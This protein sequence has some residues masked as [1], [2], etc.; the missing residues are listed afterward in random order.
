[1]YLGNFPKKESLRKVWKMEGK[2][3]DLLKKT[4]E[5]RRMSQTEL[6]EEI[7]KQG[8]E[9]YSAADVSK[10]E[11][12]WYKPPEAVVEL[13]EEDIFHLPKGLLL[14]AAGYLPAAESRR[15][16]SRS[17]GHEN[18]KD[19]FLK[20]IQRF[21]EE[22]QGVSLVRSIDA[23]EI[24][25]IVEA[26]E[27]DL[28]LKTKAGDIVHYRWQ[29]DPDGRLVLRCP[30]ECEPEFAY[31]RE[32]LDDDGLWHDYEEWQEIGKQLIL[33]LGDRTAR[34]GLR[35]DYGVVTGKNSAVRP[36]D[37]RIGLNKLAQNISRRIKTM[38]FES[39]GLPG[40]CRYCLQDKGSADV[41]D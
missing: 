37:L 3:G 27:Y 41:S 25:R 33:R 10:W 34:G 24:G 26:G 7:H 30:A 17:P 21:E 5:E 13:L 38:L 9:K 6:V 29:K 36:G 14:E 1:L 31:L 16:S 22:I 18:H 40:T 20:L 39:S 8:Y 15:L 28:A 35:D 2:F 4:R 11:H 19:R 23:P 32:H 12:E